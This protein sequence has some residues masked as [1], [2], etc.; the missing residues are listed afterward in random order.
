[1]RVL[2]LGAGALG[3]YYGGRLLELDRDITFLVRPQRAERLKKEGLF[4]ES[5][6][7]NSHLKKVPLVTNKDKEQ[8]DLI[9]LSCKAYD[10]ESAIQSISPFVGSNSCVLPVLNGLSHIDTLVQTFGADRVLGGTSIISATLDPDGKIVHLGGS[11]KMRYG[12]LAGGT[13][14]RT[15]A[16]AAVLKDANF[17]WEHSQDIMQNLWEKWIVLATLAGITCLMRGST[18]DIV[19]APAGTDLLLQLFSECSDISTAHGF[20]PREHFVVQSRGAITHPDSNLKPSMLRDLERN[21][22]VE[23]DHILGDLL[24]KAD[25]KK[26]NAPLLRAA[27]CHVKVYEQTREQIHDLKRQPVGA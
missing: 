9:V 26:V 3:G 25:S 1:M 21:N 5:P 4:I 27:Y 13:S 12:E 22:R 15:E 18:S 2:V 17:E 19:A 11:D 6:K 7:G 8:F 10:L 24:A 16:I 23:G 20:K 14:A